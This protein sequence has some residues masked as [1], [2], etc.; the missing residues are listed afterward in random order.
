M[1]RFI[2]AAAFA[3]VCIPATVAAQNVFDGTWKLDISKFTMPEKPDEYYL[4]NGFYECRTCDVPFKVKADGTD[5]PISGS[6]Y[7]D[8]VAFKVV[9]DHETEETDKKG[10]KVVATYAVTISPDGNTLT[11]K[12]SDSSNSNGGPPV[13]GKGQSNRVAKGPAGSHLISGSWRISKVDEMSD[14][15]TT[16]SYKVNGDEITMSSP[17]G[18]TYTAKLDGTQAAMKGDPGIDRVSV[19][20]IGTN[21]LEETDYSHDGKPVVVFKMT[22]EPDG[23]TANII[24]DDKLANRTNGAIATK[25]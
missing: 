11:V 24:F 3:A 13:T 7:I 15:A 1:K 19:K 12:F 18:Q 17:T 4:V 6:P 2:L 16:W 14:N 21:T 22:V 23:R 5:Q 9:N 20:I 8:T 25:Q 10:G